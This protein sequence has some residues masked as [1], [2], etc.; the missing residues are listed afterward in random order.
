[1][2]RMKVRDRP[3]IKAQLWMLNCILRSY[4]M[5]H[6]HEMLEE[7]KTYRTIEDFMWELYTEPCC[8][9]EERAEDIHS[10]GCVVCQTCAHVCSEDPRD[11]LLEDPQ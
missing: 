6:E 5:E 3:E 11:V 4:I 1:M 10:C 8:E 2:G 9:C 7:A